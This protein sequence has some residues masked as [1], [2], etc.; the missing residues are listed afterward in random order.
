M[1]SVL[2]APRAHCNQSRDYQSDHET[3]YFLYYIAC[4]E[5]HIDEVVLLVVA[6]LLLFARPAAAAVC[7]L[8]L[9]G[10]CRFA[11]SGSR[12]GSAWP[13]PQLLAC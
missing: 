10:C 13:G 1:V 2:V 4:N 5:L 8:L 6:L 7:Q 9:S 12:Q 11:S 3:L